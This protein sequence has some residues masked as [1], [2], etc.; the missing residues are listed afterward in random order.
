MCLRCFWAWAEF[1]A[2]LRFSE[3][4]PS[5]GG[6][7]SGRIGG[8]EVGVSDLPNRATLGAVSTLTW[9]P[10]SDEK[11]CLRPNERLDDVSLSKVEK[12]FPIR[13]RLRLRLWA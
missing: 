3:R 9:R 13:L 2:F 6:V 1:R 7:E 10:L 11:L 5:R 12:S 4:L 8:L